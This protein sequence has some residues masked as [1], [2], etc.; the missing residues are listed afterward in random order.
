MRFLLTQP[1]ATTIEDLCAKTA[2]RLTVHRLPLEDDDAA[3]TELRG[4]SSRDFFAGFEELTK[5]QTKFQQKT[6]KL[7]DE[8]KEIIKTLTESSLNQRGNNNRQ[9]NQNNQRQRNNNGNNYNNLNNISNNYNRINNRYS[10]LMETT[11]NSV[12]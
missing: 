11:I 12:H 1:E 10:G 7:T 5:A 9:N 4:I 6:P 2:S 3:F 8:L